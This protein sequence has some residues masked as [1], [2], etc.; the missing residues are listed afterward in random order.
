MKNKAILCTFLSL[1]TIF[2]VTNFVLVAA[3]PLASLELHD[4]DG[5]HIGNVTF[6]IKPSGTYYTAS[7]YLVVTFRLLP[8]NNWPDYFAAHS[9]AAY[10]DSTPPNNCP[11]GNQNGTRARITDGRIS[12]NGGWTFWTLIT[13][14]IERGETSYCFI[15]ID[16][17][18]NLTFTPGEEY[19]VGAHV[20]GS[21]PDRDWINTTK[22]TIPPIP[23]EIRLD[24]DYAEYVGKWGGPADIQ[25][26]YGRGYRYRWAGTGLNN[27]TWR[28]PIL[29]SG[30]WEVF[31]RWTSDKNRATNAPYTINHAD[32]QT[33]VRVNQE[34]DGGTW[35]SLGL[36]DF[37]EGS[38][39]ISLSDDADDVVIAD[40]I[41]LIKTENDQLVANAGPPIECKIGVETWFD[42]SNSLAIND[43]IIRYE[44]DFNND[45]LI[46]QEGEK[47]SHI[48][49]QAGYHQ[50]TLV[51]T[52]S[53]NVNASHTKMVHVLTYSPKANFNYTPN[54]VNVQ[55][56]VQFF[57]FSTDAGGKIVSWLWNFSDGHTSNMRN[58]AHTFS[59]KKTYTV[60]LTV[61][62]NDG[63]NDTITKYVTAYVPEYRRP[64]ANF[65]PSKTRVLVGEEISF[66]D[67]SVDPEHEQL[68]YYWDFGDGTTSTSSINPVHKYVKKG[69]Y[70]VDLKVTNILGASDIKSI[71]IE[72]IN[73]DSINEYQLDFVLPFLILVISLVSI[74]LSNLLGR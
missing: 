33:T 65:I 68:D 19:Y 7:T 62:D 69:I 41:R 54:R 45:Q 3:D 12:K 32:G 72:V 46:D 23:Y 15:E 61:T 74:F 44:W 20:R 47:V 71:N 37:N 2:L 50:I 48:F 51:V 4:F 6:E 18:T 28:F 27:C 35:F 39:T 56:P 31:A 24:D 13:E 64:T 38:N 67:I 21:T 11:W 70:E 57:D 26:G 60:S 53:L 14:V 16:P 1:I 8:L 9:F 40:A 17:I 5:K 34:K 63:Y 49:T 73:A 22:I 58:A 52:N 10:F 30:Y 36:Y 29:K 66:I 25:G 43:S 42:G 59:R 55:D